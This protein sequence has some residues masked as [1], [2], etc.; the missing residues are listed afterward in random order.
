MREKPTITFRL[1]DDFYDKLEKFTDRILR[2]GYE[3]F[4]EEFKNID[5]FYQKSLSDDSERNDH[6]FRRTPKPFYLI[7]ALYYKIFDDFNRD[8][9]NQT[10]DTVLIL[11]D[12]LSL[13][14]DKCKKERRELGKVCTHCVPNCTINKIMEIADK[15]A[16]EGYFSKRALVEQ[17]EKIRKDKPSLSVIGISCLLTLAS[18]MRSANEAGVPSRGVFLN[19][20]GCEHWADKPFPTETAIEKLRAILVEKY[21]TSDSSS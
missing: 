17:L 8:A 16:I 21:G 20:T 18:G 5:D 3:Y 1:G 12:C 10:K 7:E 13:M 15:Y 19:F 4:G 2:E 14:Q 6:S 11:P 9:F